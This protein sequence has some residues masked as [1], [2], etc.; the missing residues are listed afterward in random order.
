MSRISD[1]CKTIEKFVRDVILLHLTNH[2]LLNNA[3]HSYIQNVFQLIVGFSLH[4]FG[5]AWQV[6]MIYSE[7]L[8][9]F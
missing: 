9:S 7:P 4:S 2:F 6:D 3:Q 8:E 1:P 5:S